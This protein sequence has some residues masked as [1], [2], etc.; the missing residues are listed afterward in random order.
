M[1]EY[2]YSQED[3]F[4]AGEILYRYFIGV[5]LETYASLIQE[6]NINIGYR[7]E[8]I[9]LLEYCMLEKA[10]YELGYEMNSRPR[11]AVIPLQGIMSI[12]NEPK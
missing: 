1:E 7:Q 11:W 8:R 5:F 2:A 9:F 6:H 4:L 12:I 3:L 10:V